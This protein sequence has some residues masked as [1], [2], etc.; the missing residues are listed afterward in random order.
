M[1][2]SNTTSLG[3]VKTRSE[4]LNQNCFCV[5]LD[6]RSL[7]E[8]LDQE[9]GDSEFCETFIRPKAHLFS[10]VPVFIAASEVA[11]TRPRFF[12]GPPKSRG[13]ITVLWAR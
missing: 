9:A 11:D 3:P 1:S 4:R 13:R 6:R 10:N 7:C 5:T 12:P 2:N 8:A